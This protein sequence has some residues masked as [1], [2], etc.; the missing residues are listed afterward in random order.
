M[1]KTVSG[2][3]SEAVM[4]RMAY[5]YPGNIRD[6]ENTVQQAVTMVRGKLIVPGDQPLDMRTKLRPW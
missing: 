1:G 2:V 3:P 4:H 6:L 5:D